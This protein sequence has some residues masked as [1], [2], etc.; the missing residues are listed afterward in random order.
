MPSIK[1]EDMRK[2]WRNYDEL[3]ETPAF[4]DAL[5][6][7]FQEELDVSTPEGTTRRSFLGWAGIALAASGLSGCIR[8]PEDKILPYSAAPEEFLPGTPQYYATAAQIGGDVVG[9][10]V[11]SHDGRPT[12]VEG[13]P[14]HRST[15]GGL[16]STHQAL[17]LDLY[18]PLRFRK[19]LLN[20]KV[21]EL[22]DAKAELA[23]VSS[24]SKVAVLSESLPSV[25]VDQLRAKL[26]EKGVSWY[27]YESVSDD[28]QRAGLSAVFGEALRPVYTFSEFD[29]D[30]KALKVANTVL[31]LDAD[32]LGTEGSF[33]AASKQWA[34]TRRLNSKE[35]SLSRLYVVESNY[36][37]TGGNADHRIR[38]AFADVENFAW[39]VVAKL[40][41]KGVS[42]PAGL[43]EA[44]QSKAAA[45]K[46]FDTKASAVAEDLKLNTGKALVLAGRNQ[47]AVVHAIAAVLNQALGAKGVLVNY[48]A[49]VRRAADADGD[50]KS[51]AKLTGDLTAGNVDTLV[52]VGTNPVYSVPANLNFKEAIKKAKQV[53]YLADHADETSEVAQLV[54]PRA[55]FLEAWGDWV[56]ADGQVSLQQPLIQPLHGAVSDVEFLSL[57]LGEDKKGYELV[58]SFWK[59]KAGDVGFHQKWRRWLHLGL[60]DGELSPV[61]ASAKNAES[62]GGL[63]ASTSVAPSQE[64]LDVIFVQGFNTHDGRFAHNVWLQE[65]PDP[66]TKITWDNAVLLSHKTA[67]AFGIEPASA[68][69]HSVNY[70]DITLDGKK[71]SIPAWIMPGV[72]DFTLVLSLGYGRTYPNYAIQF[73]TKNHPLEGDMNDQNISVGF[74][75]NVLRSDTRFAFAQGATA[76]KNEATYEIAAVQRLFNSSQTPPK[77]EA[78]DYQAPARPLVREATLEEYKAN[79]TFAKPGIITHGENGVVIPAAD[80]FALIHPEEKSLY[81]DFDYSKNGDFKDAKHQWGMTID[82]N[83]CTGCNACMVACVSENNIPMVGKQQVIRG[84]EMHWIRMDR[85]FVSNS[86]D[87]DDV[88]IVHQ[89]MACQQ[90]E[91]APCENVCPVAATV[92]SPEG[93]NDMVYNRC[94]GTRYCANN[95][96]FKVRRFN[97]YNYA[98]DQDE[99]VHMQRNPNVTVRFRGVMEKCT[100]CVQ[101]I[102]QGK[103]RAALASDAS[104]AKQIIDHITPACAQGCPTKAITFGDINDPTSAVA[105]LKAGERSYGLL[106]ELNVKPRTSYLAKVRNP[107][108][109]F[110]A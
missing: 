108:P 51:I 16:S 23:K 50:M 48:Y 98:K 42:L 60:V 49:D 27:T 45:W 92:H 62:L 32:F 64:K 37:L 72:A 58:R 35:A 56:A 63:T 77:V 101:R 57:L 95:C 96:P 90:C 15:L 66:L 81:H 34:D 54:V 61:S 13:N 18:N 43:A 104:V 24:A 28:Q 53:I 44:A 1:R 22:A 5:T 38:A 41:E 71:L 20:G 14:D 80:K 3:Q 40:A 12:K 65:V 82:L 46:A 52:I 10:L 11:E 21:I 17:V 31:S 73:E 75:V 33:L 93:L 83:T 105:K 4:K 30:G 74:D 55:H 110:K 106:S 7:E 67:Q 97:F 19:P 2:Y 100:Y 91:T 69:S 29:K 86:D 79:P 88:E 85:Y 76:T 47:P 102:N 99:L 9:L 94:I 36:S 103:R 70:L 59:G 78:L 25:H 26:K 109:A 68:S 6:K 8:R 39:G 87:L 89:P 107:N 84:R